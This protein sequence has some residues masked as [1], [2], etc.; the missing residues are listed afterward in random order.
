MGLDIHGVIDSYFQKK[1]V[2]IS[3]QIESFDY[4]MDDIL[5]NIL[6]QFF[7]LNLKFSNQSDTIIESIELKIQNFHITKPIS[8]ENNGCSEIMT[9]HIARTRNSTYLSPIVVDFVSVV[10]VKEGNTI[11]TLPDKLINNIVI[12]N[13]YSSGSFTGT[14]ALGADK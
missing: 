1:N 5:P 14:L 11:T 4:Y 6:N 13:G 10:S 8:V 2:I 7:P 12:G 9:P 3:H